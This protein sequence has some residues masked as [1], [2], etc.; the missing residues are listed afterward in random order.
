MGLITSVYPVDI[1]VAS[2]ERTTAQDIL[3]NNI[4]VTKEDLDGTSGLFRAYFAFTAGADYNMSVQ[5]TAKST[6]ATAVGKITNGVLTDIEVTNTGSSFPVVPVIGISGGGGTATATAVLQRGEVIS[7]TIDTSDNNFTSVP[8]ITI[9]PFVGSLEVLVLNGDN[10]FTLKSTGYYRFDIGVRSGD[11]INFRSTVTSVTA[12]EFR[13]DQI[14]I[15][16]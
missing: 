8:T 2:G 6:A 16:A 11:E 9:T 13:V 7:I 10:V 12:I 4:I 1:T 15:G 14:Q 5:R 3:T